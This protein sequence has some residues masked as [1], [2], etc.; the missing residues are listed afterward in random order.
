MEQ[1]SLLMEAPAQPKVP[2]EARV[3]VRLQSMLAELRQADV[4]P[5][6]AAELERW[7]VVAPQ[8]CARLPEAEAQDVMRALE[9]ELERLL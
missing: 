4:M 6:T 9:R 5:W 2:V 7:R 8:M 3:R 1:L